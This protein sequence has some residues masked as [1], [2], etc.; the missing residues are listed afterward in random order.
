MTVVKDTEEKRYKV[1]VYG[2]LREGLHNHI[3][4][5]KDAKLLGTFSTLPIYDMYSVGDSFPA[6]KEDGNTS[7]VMEVYDISEMSFA[8]V[9]ALEGYYGEGEDN[10]Y[11]RTTIVTP[12]GE[13]YAYIY[14]PSIEGF[15]LVETGD[16]YKYKTFSAVQ[17]NTYPTC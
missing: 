4:L 14:A 17:T 10:F 15:T 8:N 2:S 3:T 1:A 9:N 6:L 12:Y 11:D 13:A 7:I 16:W 5:G